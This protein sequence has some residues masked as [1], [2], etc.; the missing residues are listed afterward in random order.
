MNIRALRKLDNLLMV[1]PI[2]ESRFTSINMIGFDFDYCRR[3]WMVLRTLTI[4][5]SSLSDM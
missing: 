1:S 4:N 5:D 2:L 3:N